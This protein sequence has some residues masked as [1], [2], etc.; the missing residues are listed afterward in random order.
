MSSWCSFGDSV[1]VRVIPY[2]GTDFGGETY[3]RSVL[4]YDTAPLSVSLLNIFSGVC[5][6][7]TN[8][9]TAVFSRRT[10]NNLLDGRNILLKNGNSNIKI[11]SFTYNRNNHVL[12][13]VL[14]EYLMPFNSYVLTFGRNISDIL[15]GRLPD[16]ALFEFKV[17]GGAGFHGKIFGK[18]Y[19]FGR[20]WLDIPEGALYR[21][22]YIEIANLAA[23]SDT[24]ITAGNELEAGGQ[25]S[26]IDPAAV[27]NMYGISMTDTEG[28]PLTLF[29]DEIT[30][31]VPYPD[32]DNDGLVDG[33]GIR[34]EYLSVFYYDE[35]EARWLK[36]GFGVIYTAENRVEVKISHLSVFRLAE[37]NESRLSGLNL[38][39]YPNPYF[40]TG[41]INI[42]YYLDDVYSKF[43]RIEIGI[44]S[45]SGVKVSTLEV[46]P[47][48]PSGQKWA[49][50]RAW[51]GKNAS[52]EAIAPGVYL[53]LFTIELEGRAEQIIRKFAVMK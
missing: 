11:N 40:G 7:E 45:V 51:D 21:P 19:S 46:L 16:T 24:F 15:G 9:I 22:V 33:T 48:S 34:E 3:S 36:A 49:N 53:C 44:Y 12:T 27:P 10:L 30:L 35:A 14:S 26:L 47:G 32:S 31:S 38:K 8:T 28:V 29:Q 52:G 39:I 5:P 42:S 17:P 1:R 2:D 13:M 25:V 23:E 41:D 43:S 37:Y 18:D 6:A 50:V 4:V 20:V